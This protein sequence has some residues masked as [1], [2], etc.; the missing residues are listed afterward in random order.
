MACVCVLSVVPATVWWAWLISRRCS[1]P[2]GGRCTH[3]WHHAGLLVA[4]PCLLWGVGN[5]PWLLALFMQAFWRCHGRYL[6]CLQLCEGPPNALWRW[7]GPIVPVREHISMASNHNSMQQVQHAV[8]TAA[9][10]VSCVE[11]H[12]A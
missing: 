10:A 7:E 9:H 4:R 12:V 11:M 3:A 1:M 2:R 5:A 8:V 6:V